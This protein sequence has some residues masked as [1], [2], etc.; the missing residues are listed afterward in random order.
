MKKQLIT[1]VPAA[2]SVA[3]VVVSAV[4]V[5]EI[6]DSAYARY[7]E[8]GGE[9]GF[10]SWFARDRCHLPLP[11]VEAAEEEPGVKQHAAA[12][13]RAK[14][15]EAA[16]QQARREAQR[17]K[18][19]ESKAMAKGKPH[20]ESP[21]KN[22]GVRK[23]K[24][25]KNARKRAGGSLN[26]GGTSSFTAGNAKSPYRVNG[27]RGIE[28]GSSDNAPADGAR[29]VMTVAY[30]DD[31]S[32]EFRGLKWKESKR[33]T[34]P[35]YG[36]DRAELIHSYD[37]EQLSTVSFRK[38]F[39]FTEEGLRQATEFYQAMA[40]EASADLGF[41]VVNVDRT[42]NL[43]SATVCEF[44]NGDGETSIRG[45]ISAWSDNALTVSFTVT[46]KTY[47]KE[48][49]AQSDAAYQS[50]VADSVNARIEVANR[51][52]T[53]RKERINAYLDD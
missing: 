47:A 43:K 14:A 44:R 25:A 23:R 53:A 9:K 29:P 10:W 30:L 32:T 39:P 51:D 2:I 28:F 24:A 12:A 15:L 45:A 8:R 5:R 36:F 37:T 48:V 34:D 40:A 6:G 35:V 16:K 41:D 38:S 33:L 4:L 50:G 22:A 42:D 7:L 52:N 18:E 27:I 17:R 20:K 11:G 31:G 46:D 49:K 3:F 1:M 21:G 13:E 19:A 26:T